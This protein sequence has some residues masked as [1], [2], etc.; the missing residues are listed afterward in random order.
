MS[1]KYKIIEKGSFITEDELKAELKKGY[2]LVGCCGWSWAH[3]S[4][5]RPPEIEGPNLQY[6]FVYRGG[7][8]P[9]G[10]VRRT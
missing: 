8:G 7:L 9:H 3:D 6:I 1:L 10:S 2:E 5:G 4:R